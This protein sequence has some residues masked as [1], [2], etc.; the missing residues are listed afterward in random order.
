MKI[1]K[2]GYKT[3]KTSFQFCPLCGNL[4]NTL[5]LEE[6]G[7]YKSKREACR[8]FDGWLDPN[9]IYYYKVSPIDDTLVWIYTSPISKHFIVGCHI[10]KIRPLE[11]DKV[12]MCSFRKCNNNKCGGLATCRLCLPN[13]QEK[14][15]Y[16]DFCS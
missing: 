10:S 13:L 15:P 16:F 14:Y 6:D 4:L 1:C 7:T 11:I 12:T 3:E 2:C 5:E 9:T 8:V